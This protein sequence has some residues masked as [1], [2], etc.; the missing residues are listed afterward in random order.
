MVVGS[1]IVIMKYCARSCRLFDLRDG[2]F[3][4]ISAGKFKRNTKEG[5]VGTKRKRKSIVLGVDYLDPF[6]YFSICDEFIKLFTK[7]VRCVKL[8]QF[9]LSLLAQSSEIPP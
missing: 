6:Q 4:I 7:H 1:R 3:E 8:E 2:S 9:G 5:N